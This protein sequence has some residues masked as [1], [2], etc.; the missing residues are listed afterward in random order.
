MYT[1][2]SWSFFCLVF[3]IYHAAS[4]VATK[5]RLVARMKDMQ[6]G[7]YKIGLADVKPSVQIRIIWIKRLLNGFSQNWPYPLSQHGTT[8]L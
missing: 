3:I 6:E 7:L 4:V 2:T 1:G 5:V 8:S